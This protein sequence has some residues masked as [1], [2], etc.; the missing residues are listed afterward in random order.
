MTLAFPTR[1]SPDL[2]DRLDLCLPVGRS[3]ADVLTLGSDTARES[4]LQRR[5]KRCRV[6]H[7]Q[8]R[9]R[10]KSQISRILRCKGFGVRYGFDK[11]P[12]AFGNLPK[13]AHAYWMSSMAAET[14]V[15]CGFPLPLDPTGNRR[16]ERA[17]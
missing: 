4:S 14:D 6:V 1:R 8:G 16:N 3:V 5:R 9:L 11:R 13:C 7:R 2:C 15:P 10:E 12:C 17:R